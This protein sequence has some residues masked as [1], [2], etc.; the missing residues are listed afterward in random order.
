[1]TQTQH[2]P[3]AVPAR[4]R[5][6]RPRVLAYGPLP[7]PYG[8]QAISFALLTDGLEAS[9]QW[10]VDVVNVA[11][12]DWQ[13]GQFTARRVLATLGIIGRTVA[14]LPRADLF[15]LTIGQSPVAFLR[16]ALLVWTAWLIGKRVVARVDGGAFHELYQGQG[17]WLRLAVRATVRRITRFQA[18]SEVLKQR[19]LAVPGLEGRIEVVPD[20]AET[21]ADVSPKQLPTNGPVRLLY[22]SNLMF[23]KGYADLLEAVR[24]LKSQAP[25]QTFQ[26]DIAGGFLVDPAY[27]A[28]V[29]QAKDDFWRRVREGGLH[30]TVT[31]HGVV[32]GEAKDR[33]L[34]ECHLFVLPTYYRYEGTPRSVREALSYAMPVVV[35][36]WAGLPDMVTDGE[37]GVLAP[38]KD[39]QALARAIAQAARTPE[40]YAMLSRGA[41][42][43]FQSDFTMEAYLARMAES[44]RAALTGRTRR[45]AEAGAP[46]PMP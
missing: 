43:R 7:P 27:F 8:G 40:A 5:G 28:S 34:R 30:E 2:Q 11:V 38:P 35:T 45:R 16:D 41:Q 25:E 9:G 20:G 14:R 29:E 4:E 6:K 37:S 36:N 31:H 19:F 23:D 44:F 1:M 24:L 12:S 32:T 39:P 22:L 13:P 10:R 15:Y 17:R 18:L 42:A 26:V 33:L 21:P 46:R 3:A